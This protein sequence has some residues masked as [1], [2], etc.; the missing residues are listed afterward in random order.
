MSLRFRLLS[1]CILSITALQTETSLAVEIPVNLGVGP[2]VVRAFD[3]PSPS[4][5]VDFYGLRL[6]LAAV[7]DQDT[8]KRYKT[9]IPSRYRKM[10]SRMKEVR[11]SKIWIPDRIL[12]ASSQADERLYLVGWNPISLGNSL[13]MGFLKLAL[14][15]GLRFDAGAVQHRPIEGTE[16]TPFVRP[17]ASG[18]L[19]VEFK[20]SRRFLMSFSA[21]Y[22]YYVPQA[23]GG[24]FLKWGQ[25]GRRRIGEMREF[26]M[27]LHY[28]LPYQV[29]I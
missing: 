2:S 25:D 9:K 19:E 5:D 27:I 23:I 20:F 18:D 21:S 8:I 15:L 28:R 11:I 29:R 4:G 26:A 16:S 22:T 24:G 6:S 13:T 17:G 14:G 12:F 3:S 10:A 7:I 1:A